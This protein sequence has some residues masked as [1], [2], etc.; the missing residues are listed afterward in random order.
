M[1][2]S[3][4]FCSLSF[5]FI[6]CSIHQRFP[7]TLWNTPVRRFLRLLLYVTIAF[8][9][10]QMS[11]GGFQPSLSV[12]TLTTTLSSW[13]V[14]SGGQVTAHLLMA[15][16]FLP[17]SC[18]I[19]SMKLAQPPLPSYEQHV[20]CSS[21]PCL[22]LTSAAILIWQESLYN[23]S[24]L[25]TAM[26]AILFLYTPDLKADTSRPSSHEPPHSSPPM[27]QSAQLRWFYGL[28]LTTRRCLR[29]ELCEPL[30]GTA[31]SFQRR[32]SSPKSPWP[33]ASLILL[34]P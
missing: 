20:S 29:K 12:S 13:W 27:A 25:E 33:A 11:S 10:K 26:P 30:L 8:S 3:M 7:R 19:S 15:S 23:L 16:S 31:A 34:M 22:N 18:S 4:F 28:W 9:H 1:T 14:G 6:W 32:L 24:P 5:C 21:R 2:T 17:L